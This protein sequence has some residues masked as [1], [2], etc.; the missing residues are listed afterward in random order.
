MVFSVTY[1]K[2]HLFAP[3][4]LFAKGLNWMSRCLIVPRPQI[5]GMVLFDNKSNIFKWRNYLYDDI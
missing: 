4:T 3:S 2:Y 1:T 5:T